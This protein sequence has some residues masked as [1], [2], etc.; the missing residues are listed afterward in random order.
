MI[1]YSSS[2]SCDNTHTHT[3]NHF[4]ALWILSG[5][6]R[7]SRY[8]KKHSRTHTHHGHQSSTSCTNIIHIF[9][10]LFSYVF[11]LQLVVFTC[12]LCDEYVLF[13]TLKFT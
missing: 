11:C 1:L 2:S 5:K 3:H 13:S 4:T 12:V 7:V 6:T 10:A 8:Q 9:L